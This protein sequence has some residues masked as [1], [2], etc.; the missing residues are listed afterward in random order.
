MPEHFKKIADSYDDLREFNQGLIEIMEEKLDGESRILDLASGTGRYCNELSKY[1][2][3][4][5][6]SLDLSPDML[7]AGKKKGLKI[8]S[9]V[10]KL[11]FRGGAF[12]GV[13]IFNA[14]HHFHLRTCI[15]EVK[16]VLEKDGRIFIYTRLKNQNERSVWG[17]HFPEFNEKEDRLYDIEDFE[18]TVDTIDG[19]IIEG[20]TLIKD[21]RRA[22]VQEL[23]DKVQSKHFSTFSLYKTKELEKAVEIFKDNL[24]LNYQT[25]PEIA[26]RQENIL[27]VLRKT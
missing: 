24:Q 6:F 15:T 17:K 14:I 3:F 11:P 8:R 20:I 13:I 19:I 25:Y 7:M 27:I 23:L 9:D 18:K 1:H 16:K 12:G 26:Y 2:D 4:S 22:D 21:E 10:C 5:L